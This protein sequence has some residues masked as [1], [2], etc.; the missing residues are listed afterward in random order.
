MTDFIAFVKRLDI[1]SQGLFRICNVV[2]S[3][4]YIFGSDPSRPFFAAKL[5]ITEEVPKKCF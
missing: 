2:Q 5:I 1:K 4:K 3:S